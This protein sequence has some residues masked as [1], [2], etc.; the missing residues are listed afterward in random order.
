MTLIERVC[1]SPKIG[2]MGLNRIVIRLG[3]CRY[4]CFNQYTR[5]SLY[6]DTYAVL[7]VG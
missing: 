5:V 6:C 3:K 4:T 1:A 2:N 7:V